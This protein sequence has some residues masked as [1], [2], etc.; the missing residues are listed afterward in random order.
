MKNMNLKIIEM[1]QT[2]FSYC[3]CLD[4]GQK[5]NFAGKFPDSP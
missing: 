4:A 5:M 1:I 3:E 2:F